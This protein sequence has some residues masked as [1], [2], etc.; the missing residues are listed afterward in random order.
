[1]PDSDKKKPKVNRTYKTIPFS[2][3]PGLKE[4]LDARA[5]DLGLTRSGY[6]QLLIRQDLGDTTVKIEPKETEED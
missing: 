1:M 6:L 5:K 4:E 2:C 3:P